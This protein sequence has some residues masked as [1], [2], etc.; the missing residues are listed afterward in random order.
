MVTK[1]ELCY[2]HHHCYD[3]HPYH[4]HDAQRQTMNYIN[5]Q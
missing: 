3:H 2:K 4:H 5:T 1:N